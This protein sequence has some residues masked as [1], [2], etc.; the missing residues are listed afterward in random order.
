MACNHVPPI[1]LPPHVHVA[2]TVAASV[3][4]RLTIAE[5]PTI[6]H[7]A[8]LFG[9]PINPYRIPPL[10]AGLWRV[11]NPHNFDQNEWIQGQSSIQQDI[12]APDVIFHCRLARGVLLFEAETHE[13]NMDPEYDGPLYA[14]RS[15]T[16]RNH[17]PELQIVPPTIAFAQYWFEFL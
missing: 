3:V 9:Q 5:W 8:D 13:L 12:G 4:R 10:T 1:T 17:Q 6:F 11:D 7:N 2:N 15:Y 14:L 16:V